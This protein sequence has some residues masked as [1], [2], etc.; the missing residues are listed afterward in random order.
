MKDYFTQ[1]K[2]DRNTALLSLDK[3]KILAYLKKYNIGHP[4]DDRIFWTSV[5]KSIIG[6]NVS[7]DKKVQSRK[8]LREHGFT[9][10]I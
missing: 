6:I 3:D 5:H 10:G 9:E 4:E 1:F 7:E 2:K 8:W